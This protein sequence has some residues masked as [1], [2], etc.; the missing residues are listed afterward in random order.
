MPPAS[1][2]ALAAKNVRRSEP[3][4]RPRRISTLNSAS[5]VA[6]PSK[7]NADTRPSAAPMPNWITDSMPENTFVR[8]AIESVTNAS[9][10]AASTPPRPATKADRS[11]MPACRSSRLRPIAWTA[12]STPNEIMAM[13]TIRS[14]TRSLLRPKRFA[15]P[16]SQMTDA[17]SAAPVIATAQYETKRQAH[18][19]Q[20]GQNREADERAGHRALLCAR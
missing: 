5:G 3:A 18:D 6:T 16:L 17:A 10:N 15:R 2:A 19:Q 4:P 20:H 13:G 8:N 1:T 14:S 12:K 7:R 11:G 9:S